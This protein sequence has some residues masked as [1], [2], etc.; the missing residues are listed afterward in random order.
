[1]TDSADA[2]ITTYWTSPMPKKPTPLDAALRKAIKASGMTHY[3][4]GQEA[5]VA[6]SVLDRFMLPAD[7][8]RHRDIRLE[9]ASRIAAVLGL[10]LV[11]TD[12]Q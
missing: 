8:P 12:V 7:D 11:P 6:P 2:S 1:M 9:T 4:I 5:A 10:V 3:A